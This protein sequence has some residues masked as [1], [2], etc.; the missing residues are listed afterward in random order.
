MRRRPL[1]PNFFRPACY[2]VSIAETNQL[3]VLR[4][5]FRFMIGH[6]LGPTKRRR[7]DTAAH[8]AS[9]SVRSLTKE[10]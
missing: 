3:G 8:R 7:D 4:G 9:V 5:H 2:R 10:G 6:G 1:A